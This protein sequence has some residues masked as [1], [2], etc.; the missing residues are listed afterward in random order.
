MPEACAGATLILYSL[1]LVQILN[2]VV[3][4]PL[5]SFQYLQNTPPLLAIHISVGGNCLAARTTVQASHKLYIQ[6]FLHYFRL[7]FPDIGGDP[8][9]TIGNPLST[10]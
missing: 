10:F 2:I 9:L 8:S 4:W 3:V 1:F 6:C 7:T 5:T